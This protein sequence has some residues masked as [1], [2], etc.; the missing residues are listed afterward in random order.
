MDWELG[1]LKDIRLYDEDGN[2]IEVAEVI[3]GVIHDIAKRSNV[4][5]PSVSLKVESDVSDKTYVYINSSASLLIDEDHFQEVDLN[6]GAEVKE[7]K[8]LD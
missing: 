8:F 2:E 6:I 5:T 4:P 7:F 1:E 3:F